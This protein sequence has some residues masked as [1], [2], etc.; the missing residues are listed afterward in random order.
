MESTRLPQT[1]PISSLVTYLLLTNTYSSLFKGDCSSCYAMTST[2][3]FFERACIASHGDF[4]VDTKAG[5]FTNGARINLAPERLMRCGE[6]TAF[7]QGDSP[8]NGGYVEKSLRQLYADVISRERLYTSFDSNFD[9]IHS[10]GCYPYSFFQGDDGT[11]KRCP[12]SC[13]NSRFSPSSTNLFAKLNPKRCVYKKYGSARV[14]NGKVVFT[15]AAN[16]PAQIEAIKRDIMTRGPMVGHIKAHGL[17]SASLDADYSIDGSCCGVAANSAGNTCLY[18]THQI[19]ELPLFENIAVTTPAGTTFVEPIIDHAVKI[20]GWKKIRGVEKWIIANSWGPSFG[21]NGY[22][23][24]NVDAC[25]LGFYIGIDFSGSECDKSSS[26]EIEDDETSNFKVGSQYM[27]EKSHPNVIGLVEEIKSMYQSANNVTL[28][29]VQVLEAV[30]Q[31]ATGTKYK[32]SVQGYD[33]ILAKEIILNTDMTLHFITGDLQ[34]NNPNSILHPEIITVI[35]L[36]TL[37]GVLLIG[38]CIISIVVFMGLMIGLIV[39]VKKRSVDARRKVRMIEHGSSLELL[40][41]EEH[42]LN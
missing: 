42:R 21:D 38:V 4:I 33:P 35:T 29:N 16:V 31:V 5:T 9:G 25:G 18:R 27:L 34:L 3:V 13:T 26:S 14:V 17:S 8:C 10:G 28:E 23:Y 15:K 39:F 41:M 1:H 36:G 12:N 7:S 11:T 2:S 20:V 30:T 40:R 19:Q 32:V 37:A 24:A 22:F 6:G